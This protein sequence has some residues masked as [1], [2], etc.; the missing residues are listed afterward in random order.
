MPRDLLLRAGSS[1]SWRWLQVAHVLVALMPRLWIVL[2]ERAFE[3]TFRL[4]DGAMD[5]L[6]R[7]AGAFR[8]ED[9]IQPDQAG[10]ELAD[11]KPVCTRDVAGG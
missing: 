10:F 11:M 6:V 1:S 2:A 9:R 3:S 7:S 8:D 5:R 4:A